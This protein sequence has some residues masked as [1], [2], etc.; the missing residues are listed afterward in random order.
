M[1]R[2]TVHEVS[3]KTG[4]SIRTL[5][6]Y[7]EI[8]L[9]KP[10]EVTEAGY[11]L[12]DEGDL[13][14]LQSILIYRE[15]QFP[16]R[17]ICDIMN[18]PAFERE[19]ALGEQIRLL[20]MRCEHL[21]HLIRFARSLQNRE[22]DSMNFEPFDTKEMDAY[23]EEVKRKWGGTDAYRAYEE[24]RRGRSGEEEK[25]A[26]DGLMQVLAVFGQLRDNPAE[27]ERAL[28]Q[29]AKLKEYI[30]AHF[31]PCTVDI[32]AG[33]GKMYVQDER[34]RKRIDAYGGEGPAQA[35]S[36]AIEAFCRQQR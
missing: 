23:A 27:D 32:L 21:Q 29:A 4:V 28:A 22:E 16:L 19:R 2:M 1:Q 3:R 17:A 8:G 7:D 13:E 30:S 20:E 25:Q 9:L 33:L 15:L 24:R 34:M 14:R 11:R 31:Y 36:Q 18:S 5:H 35:A 6:Y 12:Y 26:G 10:S